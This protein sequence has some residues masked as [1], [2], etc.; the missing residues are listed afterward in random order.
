MDILYVF[1]AIYLLLIFTLAV[2]VFLW[3]LGADKIRRE[4]GGTSSNPSPFHPHPTLKSP[5]PPNILPRRLSFSAAI[6]PD[7]SNPPPHNPRRV[8][9]NLTPEQQRAQLAKSPHPNPSP[10]RDPPSDPAT[11]TSGQLPLIELFPK[12]PKRQPQPPRRTPTRRPRT[13]RQCSNKNTNT[14]FPL[15]QHCG[16]PRPPQNFRALLALADKE[17]EDAVRG[18]NVEQERFGYMYDQFARKDRSLG[19]IPAAA[20]PFGMGAP[21]KNDASGMEPLGGATTNRA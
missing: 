21:S 19:L 14:C 6:T 20:Y 4:A 12:S 9:F 8:T 7:T 1:S 5:S 3:I 10:I 16:D 18:S 11:P 13:P 17:H 15:N 2:L